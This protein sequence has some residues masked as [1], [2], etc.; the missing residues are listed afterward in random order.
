MLID[1]YFYMWAEVVHSLGSRLHT[2]NRSIGGTKSKN[3]LHFFLLINFMFNMLVS[4][5]WW[6]DPPCFLKLLR[7]EYLSAVSCFFVSCILM[8]L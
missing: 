8:L 7:Q 6:R 3:A 4:S 5:L 1:L 2:L